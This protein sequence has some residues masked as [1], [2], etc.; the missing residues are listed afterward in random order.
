[1][2]CWKKPSFP[3]LC[4]AVRGIVMHVAKQVER[5]QGYITANR[6][7]VTVGQLEDSK[8]AINKPPIFVKHAI[9]EGIPRPLDLS[10]LCL[11]AMK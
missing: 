5:F 11:T 8:I 6:G 4:G 2:F 10:P 1:M 7:S 3:P 9:T